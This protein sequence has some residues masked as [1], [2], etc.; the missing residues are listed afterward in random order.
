MSKYLFDGKPWAGAFILEASTDGTTWE[1]MIA[2][3][4]NNFLGR[5]GLVANGG[6]ISS[7]YNSS[8]FSNTQFSIYKPSGSY[9][10]PKGLSGITI[11]SGELR[12][13]ST[14]SCSVTIS[15]G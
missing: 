14:A 11:N 9:S 15:A 10:E 4:G 12:E 3:S 8:A 1:T 2:K 6:T 7:G 5:E 13:A